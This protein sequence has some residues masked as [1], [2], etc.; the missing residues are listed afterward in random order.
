MNRRL[1]TALLLLFSFSQ[2]NA[3][4]GLSLGVKAGLNFANI[5]NAS[6]VNGSSRTGYM[7]GG[8]IAPRK[9]KL[10]GF[11][12]EIVLSR[13]GYNF[14]ENMNTGNINL[15]YLLIP[16][17]VTVNFSRFVQIQLGAQAAV[18]LNAKGDSSGVGTG[19]LL[20]YFSR[21]DYGLVGGAEIT[22]LKHWFFGARMNISMNSVST[23]SQNSPWYV[24]DVNAKN[25]L[26]QLYVG[27][28]F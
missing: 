19:S 14:K 9:K 23:G 5:T 26:V 25:N 6:Q 22:P 24:P 10:F 7:I 21:F 3:Q 28:K 4:M 13:Q 20:N 8:F 15:D 17:L 16:Q 11:R 12:S 18:L 27:W 2:L 1:I